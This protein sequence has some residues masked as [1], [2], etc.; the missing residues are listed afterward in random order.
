MKT[1]DFNF[2]FD[3]RLIATTPVSPRHS[4]KM[5]C[6]K[7]NII[8]HH[9]VPQLADFLREGDCLILN[10][11]KVIKARLHG[12]IHTPPRFAQ[13]EITL[14]KMLT[15][16]HDTVTYTG[17]VRGAKK[18]HI[19]DDVLFTAP[20]GENLLAKITDKY[21]DTGEVE[22]CFK[23]S[24]P[25]L[26]MFLELAGE[27]PLPPYIASKRKS[28]QSDDTHYQSV[29]AKH[30]GSVAAPT[31]SLHF[32]D[33]LLKT[34]DDKGIQKAYV[35][36]HVGGGTFLPVKT[37]NVHDHKMHSEFASLSAE[38]AE[39]LN[40]IKRQGGR[41]VCIGTTAL[42]TL[43]TATSSD[44]II[45]PYH[46][47][48]DIFITPD[49]TFRAVDILLTNFHLPKSTL[50]MLVCSLCGTDTMKH[51]YA[52]AQKMDY[53]FFSYGDACLLFKA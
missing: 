48:T 11:T 47:H 26:Y 5:M 40:R 37:D 6:I 41:L 3:D 38:T 17:F 10:D 46:D 8:T 15:H 45:H 27:M 33:V 28:N 4:A 13:F 24:L 19:H 36:L 9:H 32:D 35:T 23:S 29:F 12:K 42:R 21:P 51:A 18:L 2:P 39:K 20:T 16:T 49:Y 14:H 31:A 43:E 7:D 44:G 52:Q 30:L 34:L 50:F 22:I 1:E 25:E 53:R